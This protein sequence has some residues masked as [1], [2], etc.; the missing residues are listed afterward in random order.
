MYVSVKEPY[1]STKETYIIVG[2][3]VCWYV[4]MYISVK[5]PYTCAKESHMFV[6]MFVCKFMCVCRFVC[7][8]MYVCKTKH[9]DLRHYVGMGWLWLVG[10]I[11]L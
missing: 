4:C 9:C 5:E 1:T 8:C 10:S 2:M 7:I 6:C 3:Y 11:K